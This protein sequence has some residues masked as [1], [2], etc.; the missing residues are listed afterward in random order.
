MD[1]MKGMTGYGL[2]L[3]VLLAL[4]LLSQA[5][6]AEWQTVARDRDRLVQI[7]PATLIPAEGGIKVAWGRVVLSADEAKRRGYASVK[8]LNRFDCQR[9]T[10]TT[11]KR[12]YLDA[13]DLPLSEETLPKPEAT[14][15]PPGSVDERLWLVVC[16]PPTPEELSR[17]AQEAL[18]SAQSAMEGAAKQPAQA[19][20]KPLPLGVDLVDPSA[21]PPEVAKLPVPT[22]QPAVKPPVNR[23]ETPPPP[24]A[25]APQ[26][27]AP[28]PV[29][30]ASAAGGHPAGVPA[31]ASRPPVPREASPAMATAARRPVVARR[32]APSGKNIAAK[33]PSPGEWTYAEGPA[34]PGRWHLLSPDWRICREGKR[35][36]PIALEGAIPADLPPPFFRYQPSR[37]VLQ[38]DRTGLVLE[39]AREQ[40]LGWEGKWYRLERISWHHPGMHRLGVRLALGELVLQHRA[41]DG[42]RLFVA[43]RVVAAERTHPLLAALA[44]WAGQGS[45][46]PRELPLDLRTLEPVDAS[47]FTY[48]GSE[49]WPPC[50]EDVRWIVFRE[51]L[52]AIS[53]EIAPL[54]QGPRTSRPL[55]PRH[56][57]PVFGIVR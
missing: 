41:E 16:R 48:E 11:V 9:R 31:S 15:I 2:R 8:A 40:R 3:L 49:P 17:I 1:A 7:D 23:P 22:P 10:Y 50:R 47:Y 34:G 32:T 18:G 12:V 21:L 56:D 57:R 51:P 13:N 38:Q 46:A 53:T 54:T 24:S 52:E 6:L 14:P 20:G 4:G 33:R 25:V 35:Q 39:P 37:V 30:A 26:P 5:A 45:A 29:A 44:D 27:R 36:S 42:S 19:D 55:Q 43:L 28:A